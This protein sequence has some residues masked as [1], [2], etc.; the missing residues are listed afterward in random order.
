T[1]YRRGLGHRY[2]RM[3]QAIAGVHFNFSLGERFWAELGAI[4]NWS[5]Q[6]AALISA[7]YL[8]LLRNFRRYGWLTL[9][10]FGASPAV[11]SNFLAGRESQLEEYDGTLFGTYATTLRMS[12]VGYKNKM[13]SSLTIPINDLNEYVSGLIRATETPHADY[14]K[15]GLQQ[16]GQY[17]QLNSNILQIENE[18][19]SLIRPKRVAHSGEKPS[20]ALLRGGIEYVEVRALDVS[21]FDPV[22]INQDELRFL[23]VFLLFCALH[24]SPFIDDEE[25]E[26]IDFNQLEVARRGRDPDLRLH[27]G[28]GQRS[29]A[30]WGTELCNEMRPVAELLDA[31]NDQPLFSN[32]LVRYQEV[33]RDAELTPSAQVM[34]EMRENDESFYGFALRTSAGHRDYFLALA[35]INEGR[36][37]QLTIM[38]RESIQRQKEIEQADKV[39]FE[40]FLQDYF[41][42]E[43]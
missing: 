43:L 10:L 21:P 13:Q 38:A 41:A 31:D 23:E 22:G 42:Q 26:E 16:N 19:Y 1:V 8:G 34:R 14:E 20:H 36:R 32:A 2:G 37:N 29:L 30:D 15:I 25:Q 5:G 6:D 27:T 33:V 7:G 4:E 24:E 12:D 40:K 17:Q 3:M 11:C 9:Y 39:S 28:Q 35:D 18:Y